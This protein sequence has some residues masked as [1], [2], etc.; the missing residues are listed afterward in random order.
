MVSLVVTPYHGV[1][2]LT[3]LLETTLQLKQP[4]IKLKDAWKLSTLYYDNCILVMTPYYYE[5]GLSHYI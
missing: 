2:A 4:L 3:L 1:L 5:N